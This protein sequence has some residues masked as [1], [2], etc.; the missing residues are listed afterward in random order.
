MWRA[1]YQLSISNVSLSKYLYLWVPLAKNRITWKILFKSKVN[2]LILPFA[3]ILIWFIFIAMVWKTLMA[4]FIRFHPS[5]ADISRFLI[6][7]FLLYKYA[8]I[9]CMPFNLKWYLSGS[10]NFRVL[11]FSSALIHLLEQSCVKMLKLLLKGKILSRFW[12]L[13]PREVMVVMDWV[14]LIEE[15]KPLCYI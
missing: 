9:P 13:Y 4:L 6:S 3:L 1:C 7:N 5:V 10:S 11:S 14:M 8:F 2:S 15:F 12:P